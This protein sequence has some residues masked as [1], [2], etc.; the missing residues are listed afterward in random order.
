MTSGD[1]IEVQ[2]LPEPWQNSLE[3]VPALRSE[4]SCHTYA[5]D[6]FATVFK[7][8][9]LSPAAL[10]SAYPFLFWRVPKNLYRSSLAAAAPD[11]EILKALEGGLEREECWDGRESEVMAFIKDALGDHDAASATVHNV[12]RLVASGSWDSVT[13]PSSQLFTIL[14]R[15]EWRC[16]LG[17]LKALI[18]KTS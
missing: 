9:V 10:I 5:R 14:G 11:P 3:L 7:D 1:D 4:E 2:D 6:I 17:T 12:L 8:Q 13:P 15:D 16:R 18:E